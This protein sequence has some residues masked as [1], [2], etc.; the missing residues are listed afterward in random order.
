MPSHTDVLAL[1]AQ[2]RGNEDP[3]FSSTGTCCAYLLARCALQVGIHLHLFII[4]KF[5]SIIKG[6][7]WSEDSQQP[8]ARSTQAVPMTATKD[9]YIT[10]DPDS[11]WAAFHYTLGC[12]NSD[13]IKRYWQTRCAVAIDRLHDVTLDNT[14]T[15]QTME[16]AKRATQ[17]HHRTAKRN[18][19]HRPTTLNS[20][21]VAHIKE[22]LTV[23]FRDTHKAHQPGAFTAYWNFPTDTSMVPQVAVPALQP[24]VT[25]LARVAQATARR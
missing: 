13:P 14:L 10:V 9:S 22:V 17:A 8:Q 18:V 23:D 15:P 20:G 21:A 7:A 25:A 4:T 2:R 1:A 11:A 12:T 6:T 24:T 3:T 19:W 5:T 16:A